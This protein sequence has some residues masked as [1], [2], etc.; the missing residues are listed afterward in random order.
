M[1]NHTRPQRLSTTPVRGWDPSDHHAGVGAGPRKSP[2]ATTATAAM[3]GPPVKYSR[4][5]SLLTHVRLSHTHQ[6]PAD[7]SLW[8]DGVMTTA[9]LYNRLVNLFQGTQCLFTALAGRTAGSTEASS[10]A[11]L[12]GKLTAIA[13]PH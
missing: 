9:F 12:P 10:D 2:A 7:W 3:G 4:V 11:P 6:P 5:K 8:C 13:I 1:R